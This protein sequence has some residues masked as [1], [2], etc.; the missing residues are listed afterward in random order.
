MANDPASRVRND[1]AAYDAGTVA[2]HWLLALL[3]VA[4][5]ITGW[6]MVDLKFSPLRF[7]LFNWHKW[8]GMAALVLSAARLLWRASRRSAPALPPMPD[9]QRAA[10]RAT[11]L[12]F[13]GLFFVVPLAGWLYTSAVGVPVVWLGVLP[14]PDLIGVDKPFGDA[15]LKPLHRIAAYVLA[16]LVVL[17]I[18][19]ALKH[20]LVDRDHLMRRIWPWWPSRSPA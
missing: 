12:A 19:A 16:T 20:Q 18:G 7:R 2:L 9:W 17:H 5:S 1:P 8:I 4:A 11:H 13:Y 6:I 15:V 14:V 10:Y 3:I